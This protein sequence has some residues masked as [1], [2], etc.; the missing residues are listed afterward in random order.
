MPISFCMYNLVQDSGRGSPSLRTTQG[1]LITSLKRPPAPRSY[2]FE[3]E[4]VSNGQDFGQP[5]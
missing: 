3:S 1:R 4:S 5:A 2:S